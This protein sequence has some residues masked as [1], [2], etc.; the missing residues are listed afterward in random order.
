MSTARK[1]TSTRRFYSLK[2]FKENVATRN[3]DRAAK[4][5]DAHDIGWMG[6]LGSARYGT[7]HIYL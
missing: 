4:H 3:V 2:P 5:A 6:A 7:S 1:L